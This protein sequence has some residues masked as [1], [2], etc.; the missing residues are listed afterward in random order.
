MAEATH[1]RN[2]FEFPRPTRKQVAKY[3]HA[4]KTP[5]ERKVWRDLLKSEAFHKV[6]TPA[7]G[8]VGRKV[9]KEINTKEKRK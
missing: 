1:F 4:S 5:Q 7:Q 8:K 3:L 9:D 6:K 2:S